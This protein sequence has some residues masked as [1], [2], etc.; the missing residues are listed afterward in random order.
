[1]EKAGLPT[2]RL[3]IKGVE[4]QVEVA[5]TDVDRVRGLRF[6][7][8]LPRGSGMAFLFPEDRYLRF[9]MDDTVV[10]LSIA[11]VA[12]EG[13]IVQIEDMEPLATTRTWA[14]EK[15]PYAIEVPQ[16]WFR[17]NGIGVG[18][19]VEGLGDL[20]ARSPPN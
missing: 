8:E 1:M 20:V 17:E 11:F 9:V 10:P 12:R 14:L 16:G 13:T 2:A 3:L 5:S 4:L 7:S 15:V 18:D 19:R 6:R